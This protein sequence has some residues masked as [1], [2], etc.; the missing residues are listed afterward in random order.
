MF[1]KIRHVGFLTGMAIVLMALAAVPSFPK[2][3]DVQFRGTVTKV[4]LASAATASITLRVMGFD[5]P[6]RVAADTDV[7]SEGDELC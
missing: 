2:G 3:T 7:E 1:K 6:V 4:D 5:V